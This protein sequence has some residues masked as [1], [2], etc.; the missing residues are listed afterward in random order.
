MLLFSFIFNLFFRLNE[1]R[2]LIKTVNVFLSLT[3]Y[4]FTKKSNLIGCTPDA[5]K[6]TGPTDIVFMMD[7]SASLLDT[8][9]QKEKDFIINVINKVGPLSPLGLRAGVV[10]YNNEAKIEIALNDYFD[11]ESFTDAIERLDY[12]PGTMTRIDLG[13]KE[14][15][16]S[17]EEENGARGLSKK[18][19]NCL[20]LCDCLWSVWPRG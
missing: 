10:L 6:I 19:C 13:L 2:N 7:M 20:C 14:S 4:N 8:G 18:V 1:I 3:S 15:I 17:F 16:R 9:F 12:E 5:G 11:R